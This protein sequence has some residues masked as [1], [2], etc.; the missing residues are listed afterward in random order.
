MSAAVAPTLLDRMWTSFRALVHVELASVR[1][2]GTY[3]YTVSATSGSTVDVDPN[4]QTQGLPS[5]KGWPM[6]SCVCG[7]TSSPTVGSKC[8]VT[9]ENGDPS[10]PICVGIDGP[11]QTVTL[12]ATGDVKIG[13]GGSTC[14][15]LGGTT[16]SAKLGDTVQSYVTGGLTLMPGSTITVP[17]G[18]GPCSGLLIVQGTGPISGTITTGSDRL[19]VP[20]T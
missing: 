2:L 4:D 15:I 11:P 8:L 18:G 13:P 16:P 12:D 5:G 17:P 19:T 14:E 7:A 10:L 9:F 1:F 6:R 20:G 3:G